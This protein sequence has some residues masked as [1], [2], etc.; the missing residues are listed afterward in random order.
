MFELSNIP[1]AVAVDECP[2]PHS[3]LNYGLSPS[4]NLYAGQVYSAVPQAPPSSYGP[5]PAPGCT[6]ETQG[7]SNQP[8]YA[9]SA[10]SS[11]IWNPVHETVR[12]S[13]PMMGGGPSI[14]SPYENIYPGGFVQSNLDVPVR[15]DLQSTP[16][17]MLHRVR[18]V[19]CGIWVF[20]F[21]VVQIF[22]GAILVSVA[23]QSVGFEN[24]DS[25]CTDDIVAYDDDYR[26]GA[27][28]T[29]HH[30]T[31]HDCVKTRCVG[32]ACSQYGIGVAFIVIGCF[33][34]IFAIFISA[35]RCC[36]RSSG[37]SYP[38]IY[39][40]QTTV[41]VAGNRNPFWYGLWGP[42]GHNI[43]HNHHHNFGQHHSP[44]HNHHN[45]HHFG[46]NGH[47]IHNNPHHNLGGHHH[48]HHVGHHH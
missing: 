3:N 20:A 16:V 48:H 29:H 44:L 32:A 18:S 39:G 36:R 4:T 6:N 9:L 15:S 33:G 34:V 28:Y 43:Y 14:S 46:L 11:T 5:T 13:A 40:G 7:Y 26:N 12:P 37:G 38:D 19:S 31:T 2:Q 22:I 8:P 47:N 30:P 17:T 42:S 41:I 23:K 45:H 1:T 10:N 25:T 35:C 21:C 24:Y 27:R